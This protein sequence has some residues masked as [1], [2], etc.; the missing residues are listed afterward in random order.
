MMAQTLYEEEVSTI[1]EDAMFCGK[2]GGVV[3]SVPV[4]HATPG[5]FI[6]HTNYRKDGDGMRRSFLQ[7]NPTMVSG[8]CASRYQPYPETLESMR[9]G[10]LSSEWTLLTQ[11]NVTLAEVSVNT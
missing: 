7:V 10:A 8:V 4:F 9:N 2:A 3:S 11:D 1:I 6:L 5:S